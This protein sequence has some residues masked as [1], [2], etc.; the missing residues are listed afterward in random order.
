MSMVEK[1][2]Y[3]GHFLESEKSKNQYIR[4][5]K[6]KL[7]IWVYFILYSILEI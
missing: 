6:I 1:L 3:R 5:I 4:I 2:S 7:F